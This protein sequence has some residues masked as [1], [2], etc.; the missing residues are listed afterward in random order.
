MDDRLKS[1]L[2]D[3]AG[4]CKRGLQTFIA[5]ETHFTGSVK[6]FCD[7]GVQMDDSLLGKIGAYL[8][9]YQTSMMELYVFSF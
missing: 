6:S 8:G 3:I 1:D 2:I 5:R 4:L 9:P 7:I